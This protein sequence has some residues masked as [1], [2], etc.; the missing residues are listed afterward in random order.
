MQ[1][2]MDKDHKR[3]LKTFDSLLVGHMGY[4]LSNFVRAICFG[5]TGSKFIKAPKSGPTANYYKQLTRMS[6]ALSLIS[7]LSMMSLGGDLKR[8]ESLSARLGDVLSHLYMASAVLKYYEDNGCNPDDLTHVHWAIRHSLYEIQEAFY[9]AF[10]NFPSRI[11]GR[12]FRYIIFP[13]GRS[14][15]CPSDALGHK[16]ANLMM[17]N[18][19]VRCRFTE[20]IWNST[21]PED[22]TGSVEAA[23]QKMLAVEP[24]TKAIYKGIKAGK[25]SKKLNK[26]G[27]ITKAVEAGILTEEEANELREF[28]TLRYDALEVDDFKPEYFEALKQ[29]AI[30]AKKHITE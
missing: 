22:S 30:A 4:G 20:S 3:G 6:T 16:L 14:Y 26:Q 25:I 28:E 7:G 27:R 2:L 12:L 19:S 13:L 8:K 29:A 17:T 9:G 5:F 1:A 24:L 18:N 15:K 11:K 10:R 21:D 23:F